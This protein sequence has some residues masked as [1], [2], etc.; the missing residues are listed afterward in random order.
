MIYCAPAAGAA[1]SR[2]KDQHLCL[3]RSSSP[4]A[5]EKILVSATLPPTEIIEITG[6]FSGLQSFSFPLAK[7]LGQDG[8]QV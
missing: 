8:L 2:R 4:D 3:M 1:I 7:E 6:F 5:M